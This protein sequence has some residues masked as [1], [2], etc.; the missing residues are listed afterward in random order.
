[1]II[2]N[3]I[4]GIKLTHDASV[5]LIIGNA[6]IFSVELEKVA[7]G[8]RYTKLHRWE[9]VLAILARFGYTLDHIE[10][11]A[12][13][14]WKGGFIDEPWN[15]SV[16]PYHEFD[17]IDSTAD[18]L[19][20][21]YQFKYKIK[22][23]DFVSYTHMAGH[24]IG[25]Y[26]TSPFSASGEP[27]A[28][29][30][31]DGGQNPRV[32]IVSPESDPFSDAGIEYIGSLF[33]YYGIIYGIMGYYFGPYRQPDVKRLKSNPA[34][35]GVELFGGYDRPGKLMAYI[36][37]GEVVPELLEKVM[38]FHEPIIQQLGYRQD[39]YNEH[40]LMRFIQHETSLMPGVSDA[41]ILATIHKALE[42]LLVV[43]ATRLIPKGMPLCFAGGSALNIKWNSALRDSG[44]F[45]GV[46]VPPFPNDCGS[47][48]GVAAC[49]M[50][51]KLGLWHLSWNVYLGPELDYEVDYEVLKDW[52]SEMM[53][54][55]RLGETIAMNPHEPFVVL[56]GRAELGP[57]ALGHRS[58]MMS[59]LFSGNKDILNGLKDREAFRPVAPI[60]SENRAAEIFDPGT[61]DPYM[62]FDH[63]VRTLWKDTIPAVVHL[64]GTSRLQTISRKDCP[65]TAAILAGHRTISGVPLVC[66]TSANLHG[67]GFFPD[68]KSACDWA[69]SAGVK[70]VWAEGVLLTLRQLLPMSSG[71]R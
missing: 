3:S 19:P 41:D 67:K 51:F 38:R 69:K 60:C 21:S 45:A 56:H 18:P 48:I 44:H 8:D 29:L 47:A 71:F 37:K 27:A 34:I 2:P 62:L 43:Q 65:T 59:P 4:L 70:Y 22:G 42:L 20:V 46:W 17:L 12:I 1:M 6:L 63:K 35:M 49:H 53:P 66:N 55:D 50:A 68:V 28:V 32:H 64:D 13:D 40:A 52:D 9:D 14:G 7:N 15:L 31:W 54:P 36:A 26:V 11:V 33:P 24:I 16:A 30:T 25:A 57:R 61:P 58:I 39:G 23:R 5:A 10:T